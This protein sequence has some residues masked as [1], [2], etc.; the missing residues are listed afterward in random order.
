MVDGGGSEDHGSDSRCV[1]VV[2]Q[3]SVC[4]CGCC[5]RGSGSG[6]SVM[7]IHMRLPL[8]IDGYKHL[9]I[10]LS[11]AVRLAEIVHRYQNA[12]R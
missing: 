7:R 3:L 8:S 12:R 5:C 2:I 1:V 9:E 6:V 10:F 11:G 4:C